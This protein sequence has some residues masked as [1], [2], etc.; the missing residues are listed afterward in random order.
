MFNKILNGKEFN[1]ATP[2]TLTLNSLTPQTQKE[3]LP[4]EIKTHYEI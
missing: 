4:R 3:S 1:I 2:K